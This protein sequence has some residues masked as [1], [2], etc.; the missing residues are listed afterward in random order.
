MIVLVA[1]TFAALLLAVIVV[2]WLGKI[3]GGTKTER[4]PDVDPKECRGLAYV[5]GNDPADNA[6][7]SHFAAH[8]PR[9]TRIDY[10]KEYGKSF[11][12][13]EDLTLVGAAGLQFSEEDQNILLH[14]ISHRILDLAH[15][16]DVDPGKVKIA[17]PSMVS[18]VMAAQL[19][20]AGVRAGH[21]TCAH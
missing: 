17:I 4:M 16:R 13:A 9:Y 12:H 11:V 14:E 5:A 8:L 18:L 20:L 21:R 10:D 7:T 1:C 6:G 3:L 2:G 15:W 19:R